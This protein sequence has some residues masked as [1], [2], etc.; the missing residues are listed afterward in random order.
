MCLGSVLN[1][2]WKKI[3]KKTFLFNESKIVIDDNDI[4]NR[5]CMDVNDNEM[6]V[7]HPSSTA[8]VNAFDDLHIVEILEIHIGNLNILHV[9]LQMDLQVNPSLVSNIVMQANPSLPWE[10]SSLPSSNNDHINETI[11][12][13]TIVE[14]REIYINLNIPNSFDSPP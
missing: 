10:S 11:E 13:S 4:T 7:D 5:A 1:S 14:E 3:I 12:G 6:D 2:L 9:E 8:H